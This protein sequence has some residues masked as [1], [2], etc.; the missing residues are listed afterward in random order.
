MEGR[1]RE[2]LEAEREALTADE[3]LFARV[4]AIAEQLEAV[5]TTLR[6]RAVSVVGDTGKPS[7]ASTRFSADAPR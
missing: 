6:T 5:H 2:I 7:L 3:H 1:A 4:E